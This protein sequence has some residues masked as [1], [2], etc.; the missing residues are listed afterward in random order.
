MHLMRLLSFY[1]PLRVSKLWRNISGKGYLSWSDVLRR[2]KFIR[3]CIKYTGEQGIASDSLGHEGGWQCRTCLFFL[4]GN[5]FSCHF[6]EENRFFLWFLWR[7]IF[8]SKEDNCVFLKKKS[9]FPY[10][11]ANLLEKI[12]IT[13]GI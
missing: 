8:R 2:W 9:I 6:W 12:Q 4:V 10:K 3:R 13:W 11:K 5:R 7:K 1:D